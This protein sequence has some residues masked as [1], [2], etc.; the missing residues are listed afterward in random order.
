MKSFFLLGFTFILALFAVKVDA[1]I[2]FGAKGGLCTYDLGV[3][4]AIRVIYNSDQFALNV[5][6][7][8]YGYHAGIVIQARIGSFVIQ[9]EVI[10]NSNSVDYSFQE[11]SQSTPSNVFTERYQNLDIPLLLGLKA[12]P[13]RLMAGPVGHYFLSSSSE[14]FEF[15]DYAQKFDDVTFGWQAGI[16]L[17][18]L[19]LMLD[20]RY[21][22]NFYTFGDHIVFRGQ[23]YAFDNSPARLLA[24]LAITIK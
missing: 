22:G 6:D 5:Q 12:G 1:Q 19:N 9:P 16:G 13:L 3:N 8:R 2:K 17:D 4:E 7:A 23:S 11:V 20:I 18:L 21:E 10:F 14:L 15:E 24:S